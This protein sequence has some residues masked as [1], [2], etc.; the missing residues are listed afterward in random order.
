MIICKRCLVESFWR[1]AS[2]LM[3]YSQKLKY[4]DIFPC[5]AGDG[6][7][8]MGHNTK[9]RGSD[10]QIEVKQTLNIMNLITFRKKVRATELQ[11]HMERLHTYADTCG[12][13]RLG[14]GVSAT[15]EVDG[16]EMDIE[17]YLPID[18]DIPSNNEFVYKPLLHLENCVKTYYK[19]HPHGLQDSMQKLNNYILV[20]K[21]VPIS[22]GFTVTVTE[23]TDPK[24]FELFEVF[25]Y[26]SVSPNVV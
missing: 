11:G 10:M 16:D 9:L 14:G 8:E 3:Q 26:V 15:Y 17:M 24:N 1:I 4:S 25:I 22:V 6:T 2:L 21:L 13:K 5:S 20:N 7:P 18:K 19:G 12:A 23:I